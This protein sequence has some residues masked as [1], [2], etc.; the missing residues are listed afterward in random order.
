MLAYRC[1]TLVD[2]GWLIRGILLSGD[3]SG[4]GQRDGRAV[5]V[6]PGPGGVGGGGGGG[7]E[8]RERGACAGLKVQG[9][10]GARVLGAGSWGSFGREQACRR[11]RRGEEEVQY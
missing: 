3:Y 9:C 8:L 7:L 11:Q 1:T 4:S 5:V 6:E 2:N 10:K